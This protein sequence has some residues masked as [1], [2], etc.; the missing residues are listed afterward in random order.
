MWLN[1]LSAIHNPRRPF[2]LGLCAVLLSATIITAHTYDLVLDVTRAGP[3][4]ISLTSHFAVF[5]DP[6]AALT[7]ADVTR[8]EFAQ[9]FKTEARSG[10]ALGFSYTRSA[11][12]LRPHLQNYSALRCEKAG[13]QAL[14]AQGELVTALKASEHLL[15]VRVEAR[16]AELQLLNARR[17]EISTTDDC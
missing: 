11:V 2:F 16:T 10:Q 1:C 7:L 12:W 4:A 13:A 15:E 17:E 3:E 14:Q 8:P 6:S 5:E 9:R